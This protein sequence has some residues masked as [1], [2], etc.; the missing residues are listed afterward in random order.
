MSG[1][2]GDGRDRLLR[3][4][5]E[6]IP[7]ERIE[8]VHLFP[9][10]RQ[11]GREMGVA[12]IAVHPESPDADET[13]PVEV[14]AEVG[15][16][17]PAEADDP[18]AAASEPEAPDAESVPS[19]AP[20]LEALESEG[21]ESEAL[22]PG[23]PEL[24]AS[25]PDPVEQELPEPDALE[26][27]APEAPASIPPRRFTIYRASYRLTLKGAERGKW[28]VAIVEEADAPA[29]TVEEVVRG[30]HERAAVADDGPERLTGD[31]FRAL[32]AGAGAPWTA[33]R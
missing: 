6:R 3:A 2:Q 18:N 24:A 12:V 15:E 4:I 11:G 8:E 26:P 29:S 21:P 19:D 14:P 22:E 31:A 16:S 27:D 5:A 13:A 1:V 32:I 10:I 9:A 33:S 20:E 25:E 23:S 17:P 28:E 30:V 7:P